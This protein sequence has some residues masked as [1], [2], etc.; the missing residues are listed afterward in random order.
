MAGLGLARIRSMKRLF[1]IAM[2]LSISA[3]FAHAKEAELN[4]RQ[5]QSLDAIAEQTQRDQV[6]KYIPLQI[7]D[8]HSQS[9]LYKQIWKYQ[10]HRF[11][12]SRLVQWT[13]SLQNSIKAQVRFDS[14]SAH[15]ARLRF[16]VKA[17]EGRAV[18]AYEGT[19]NAKLSYDALD[20]EAELNIT[21]SGLSRRHVAFSQTAKSNDNRSMILVAFN[22]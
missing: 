20:H 2:I 8:I 9:D 7:E 11:H 13:S 17:L 12:D 14:P 5:W 21:S 15:H 19:L 3:P 16:D 22:W 6:A 4:L 1:T 10:V 18:L